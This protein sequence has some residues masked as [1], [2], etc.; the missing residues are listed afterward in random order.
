M[1]KTFEDFLNENQADRQYGCLMLTFDDDGWKEEME[2]MVDENDLYT[3]EEG[4]GLELEPHCTV[5]YGFHDDDF[6]MNKCIQ[7]CVP[8]EDLKVGSN[9]ISL[10]KNEKYDVLKY[11]IES[12]DLNKLN[13]AFVKNFK[14]TNKFPEYHAHCTIAYL[15]PGT[16]EKYVKKVKRDFIPVSFKYSYGNRDSVFI[17]KKNS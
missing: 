16:G 13:S 10:F 3:E 15:K 5:L 17:N 4:H 1:I 11:D 12:E 7:M 9:G 2:S 6:D 14:H 8:C